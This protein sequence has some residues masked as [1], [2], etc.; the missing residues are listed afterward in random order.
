MYGNLVPSDTKID[1]VTGQSRADLVIC[2]QYAAPVGRQG[3]VADHVKFVFEVK[4][5]SATEKDINTD[6]ARLH[7]FLSATHTQARAFL[8]VVCEGRSHPRFIKNGKSILGVHELPGKQGHFR[9][10]RTVKAAA[11]F[12]G[13][14]TAHYVCLIEVFLHQ[15]DKALAI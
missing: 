15:T 9:V 4:R 2:D 3:N 1:G 13:K 7:G 8:F 5:G 10:R 12:S 6:L 14:E 11:S